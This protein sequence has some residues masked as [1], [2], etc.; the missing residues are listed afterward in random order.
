MS[1][2]TRQ[3]FEA[4][5]DEMKYLKYVNEEYR[6]DTYKRIAKDLSTWKEGTQWYCNATK[7]LEAN[8]AIDGQ[9]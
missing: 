3:Q 4:L 1:R 7:D 9:R 6:G 5:S 2:L 8:D